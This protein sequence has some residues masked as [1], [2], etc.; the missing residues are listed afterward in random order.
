MPA[1]VAGSWGP[2]VTAYAA[3]VMGV[4]LDRW[5]RRAVNRALAVR[6]DG[7]L[8]HRIYLLSVG[9]QQGKSLLVRAILG[10]ALTARGTPEGWTL[11]LGLAHDKTQ[12]RI[13]YEGVM[14]D[15]APV[16][17]RVGPESRGGLAITR[18]LGIRS[19]MYGQPRA[20]HV[21]SR[22]APDAIRSYS[23]DLGVFDEVRTQRD[24]RV[25]AALLPTTSARPD[26]LIFAIST[27]GDD[28]SI[29]LREMFDRLRRIV[30][31]A[32]PAEGFGGE[33]WAAPDDARPDDPRAWRASSPAYAEGRLSADAIRSELRS[34]GTVA[35]RQERLNLWSDAVDEW[36]PAGTWAATRR[37]EAPE[38]EGKRVV[39][40]VDAAPTWRRATIA[41]A[42][43]DGDRAYAGIVADLDAG[44]TVAETVPPAALVAALA[45]QVA[46]WRPAAVVYSSTWAGAPHVEAWCK[47]HDVPTVALTAGGL[48]TASELG[49]SELVAGRLGHPDDPLLA[50]QVRHARPSVPIEGGGWFL[51]WR[52]STGEI[53]AIRAYLWA[54]Y[55]AIRPQ[56]EPTAP[57]VFL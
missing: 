2:D 16:R 11:Y 29:L 6:P 42:I 49:R 54:A 56:E 27:A 50:L 13:P 53:D 15:L 28:R 51:S 44:L 43:V 20:Y 24:G 8:V 1:D 34:L 10:W 9:R 33:W 57:Q 52:E 4:S 31:G 21:G 47:D 55:G 48:R 5:Q 3:D 41:A 22:E 26:P 38:S 45:D 32:E 23:V 7:H 36:L 18:Y 40:G 46:R 12:A 25:W 19:A 14:A 30:D 35:F 39:L 37:P 17:D